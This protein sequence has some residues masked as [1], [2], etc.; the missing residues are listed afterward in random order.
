MNIPSQHI[1]ALFTVNFPGTP[2]VYFS[3]GRI[4][5]IG[6][7]I[8]YNDGFVM[9]AAISMGTWF[10]VA[11]NG[12]KDVHFIAA[13]LDEHFSGSLDNIAPA[14]T[15]ANY[16][17]GVIH[18]FQLLDIKITGFNCVFG[19]DLPLGAGMSSSA[20]LEGGLAFALN[21][22]FEGNL[23]RVQLALLCQRAQH[24]FPGVPCG[25]MGQFAHI[26]GN[27][28]EMFVLGRKEQSY[29]YLPLDLNGH[30]VVLIN[31][32]VHHELAS[33]EYAVRRRQCKD[34]L[35]IL[36]NHLPIHSF[37]DIDSGEILTAF[38]Q[39]MDETVYRRC[40]FVVEEIGRVKKAEAALQK[41]D[42]A[43]LGKLLYETHAGLSRLYEVSCPE[44]DFLVELARQEPGV[45]GARMMGGGFGGCTINLV[46]NHAVTPF[47]ERVEKKY[48]KQFGIS[49]QVYIMET[50]NGTHRVTG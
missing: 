45:A 33:G 46:S 8:D 30:S 22:I 44:L 38:I 20:A 40:L 6:E 43:S 49:P 31:S 18:E 41:G 4:N 13:D 27:K 48:A 37:R 39:D 14:K 16:V 32:M 28:N 29:R 50:A 19:G 3:P 7:H 5:L 12:S 25:I 23:D 34:G 21:D 17:L 2:S 1:T 9:P 47:I 26:L 24:G 11:A 36:R 10:A 35:A 42:L 15:W